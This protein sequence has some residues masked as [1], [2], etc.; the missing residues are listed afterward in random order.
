MG[1][2]KAILSRIK[3]LCEDKKI[4]LNML[5]NLSGITPSTVY[6]MFEEV[7]NDMGVVALKKICDGLEISVTEFF[8]DEIFKALEQE[9]H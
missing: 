5:A 8:N 1:I 2:K 3:K 4:T 7:H 9:I 6:S